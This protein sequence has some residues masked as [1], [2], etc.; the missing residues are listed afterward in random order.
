MDSNN[1][2]MEDLAQDVDYSMGEG[3]ERQR[4]EAAALLQALDRKKAARTMAVPTDDKQVKARLREMGEP[5]ILF[6]EGPGDRRDR[7][8]HLLQQAQA[9]RGDGMDIEGED[10]DDSDSDEEK[11]DEFYT[12]GSDDLLKARRKIAEF[13]LARARRRIAK[14]REEAAIP[15]SRIVEVRKKLYG[16]LKNYTQLGSQIGDERPISQVRYSPNSKLLLTASW[17]G[18]ARVWDMPNCSLKSTMRGHADRIGGVAWHP[19][20]TISQSQEAVNFA[21]GA[22]DGLVKIWSLASEKSLATLEGHEGRVC[23][24]AFHPSGDYIGSAS[25]D[26]TWRLW[27]VEKKKE[28]LLQEGHSKE[29]FA[30]AF[31][32]DGALAASGGFDAIGRVWDVRTGRT[33]MVLD[34]HIREILS[35]D[36]APN[37]YQVA[38]G[39]GDDSI[40]IWDLRALK[41]SYSIPAHKS[42]VSDVRWFRSQ[43]DMQFKHATSSP[44]KEDADMNGDKEDK[45]KPADISR[46]GLYLASSGFDHTVKIWSAD[47]WQLVNSLKTDEGKV[48]SVDVAG[49]GKYIASGSYSRSFHLFANE[50]DL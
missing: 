30:L 28:I 47:D 18:N 20:A 1:V 50:N 22:A 3:F 14:Q 27:D 19:Q 11:E 5:A 43:E 37:G 39:S 7:L 2:D 32:D 36:F 16:D 23:R 38:A 21:T 24:I 40:R 49:D 41:V 12:P 42:S 46:S 4:A 48:M 26:G 44:A 34:G 33:A 6:G 25:Y 45:P 9:A 8:K 29:V 17:T 15:L 10:T 13:S 31:Q 35:L